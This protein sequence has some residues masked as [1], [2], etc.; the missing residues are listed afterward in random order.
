[1]NHF[2]F[3]DDETGEKFI[4]GDFSIA[5][6][7]EVACTVAYKPRYIGSLTE[8]EAELSGLDEY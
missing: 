4:V 2:L 6:A 8:F 7:F 1:M 3:T 5:R